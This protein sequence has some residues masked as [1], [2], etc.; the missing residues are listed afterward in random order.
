MI[1]FIVNIKQT[2]RGAWPVPDK[3]SQAAIQRWASGQ[4]AGMS[5]IFRVLKRLPTRSKQHHA[6]YRLRNS[7]LAPALDMDADSLHDWI[8]SELD[9]TEEL[10][11]AGKQWTRLRSQK[12]F[13]TEEMTAMMNKQDELR[14]FVNDGREVENYLI[15]PSGENE[16]R[17]QIGGIH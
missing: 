2:E 5:F 15:L 8:K 1:D 7:I 6:L 16:D 14:D 3:E 13:S 9:M 4:P 17:E 10:T 11:V 12:E